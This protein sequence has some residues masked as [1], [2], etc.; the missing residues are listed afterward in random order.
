M[1]SHM[2]FMLYLMM[3]L[4]GVPTPDATACKAWPSMKPLAMPKKL[5]PSQRRLVGPMVVARVALARCVR[6][7][8]AGR[9]RT[10]QRTRNGAATVRWLLLVERLRDG[11][12]RVQHKQRTTAARSDT[13]RPVRLFVEA[14]QV[15]GGTPARPFTPRPVGYV[16]SLHRVSDGWGQ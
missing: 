15:N 13:S 7:G 11:L 14:W 8:G 1:S 2:G 9:E 3:R 16:P 12:W 6:F 10:G 5:S 4:A